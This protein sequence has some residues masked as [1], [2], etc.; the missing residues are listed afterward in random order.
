MITAET[1]K[2]ASHIATYHLTEAKRAYGLIGGESAGQ[3]NADKLIAW[4]AAKN[5]EP[6][7]KSFIMTHGPN[8]LRNKTALGSAIDVLEY[9]GIVKQV[10]DGKAIMVEVNPEYI[11]GAS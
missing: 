3:E 2:Q 4:M 9:D 10:K 1:M 8:S 5:F 11:E 7:K 6:T